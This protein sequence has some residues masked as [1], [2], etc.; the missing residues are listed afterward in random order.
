MRIG[1]ALDIA[2]TSHLG[3]DGIGYAPPANSTQG[4][5]YHDVSPDALQYLFTTDVAH[6][7]ETGFVIACSK[8]S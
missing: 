4:T 7:P 3:R 6:E 8:K 5:I 1:E 2:G